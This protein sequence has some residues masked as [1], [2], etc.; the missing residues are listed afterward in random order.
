M[1]GV[2]FALKKEDGPELQ[3]HGGGNLIQTLLRHNIHRAR[4]EA[5]LGTLSVAAATTPHL[6]AGLRSS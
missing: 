4:R 1:I 3:V 5:T 6:V 2:A